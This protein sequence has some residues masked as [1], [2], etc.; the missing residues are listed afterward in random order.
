MVERGPEDSKG[1]SK[2]ERTRGRIVAAARQLFR[3]QGFA[4][5]TTRAI[6][7]EA[8]CAH[9]TLFR[10]APTKEDLVEMIFADVIGAALTTAERCIPAGSFTDVALHFY[11]A[12]FR[13]YGD[14][15]ALARVLVKELPFLQGAA[16]EREHARTFA[17]LQHLADDVAARQ[18]AGVVDAAVVPMVA[19]S[20]SF[21]LYSTCLLG[22]LTGQF[23]SD[24]ALTLLRAQHELLERG[25]LPRPGNAH[26]DEGG[27]T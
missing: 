3:D 15:E 11:G 10:Y 4:V 6:A 27:T 1:S 17:L 19:A 13:T 20:A 21:A 7:V 12:F 24:G 18:L 9:G 8:G 2:A 26:H 22:W 14:D 25:L 16:V 5:T 23:D